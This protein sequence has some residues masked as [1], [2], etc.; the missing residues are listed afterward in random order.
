M[1]VCVCVC[2][3]VCMCVCGVDVVIVAVVTKCCIF[4]EGHMSFYIYL[5][6]YT[7]TVTLNKD[8]TL[9]VPPQM[10]HLVC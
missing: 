6:P 3:C 9:S 1:C 2:V 10:E 8:K 7:Q 5:L 4:F